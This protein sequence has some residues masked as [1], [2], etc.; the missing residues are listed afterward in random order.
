[1]ERSCDTYWN[2]LAS[3]TLAR[4]TFMLP[5]SASSAIKPRLLLMSPM[6]SPIDSSGVVTSTFIS[7][8]IS[9]AP[10]SRRPLRAAARPAISNAITDESTSWN[11]PSTSV[12]LQPI[13]GKPASTPDDMTDSSPLATP[14]MYSLGTV[15]PLISCAKRKPP[16]SSSGSNL[17]ITLANWPEPPDCFLCV[18]SIVQGRVIASRYATCGGPMSHSTLN[19]RFIRSQMIS[20]CSSPIP[21]MTVCPESSSREKRKEGSSAASLMSAVVIFS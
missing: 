11:A 14:G 10:A 20:R 4:T 16:S 5:R 9:L 12:A 15:P 6:T 2:M 17:T 8:S 18:C 3:G 21:S 13:T 19:S 7:G 1:M